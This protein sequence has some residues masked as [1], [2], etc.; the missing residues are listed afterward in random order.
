MANTAACNF[1]ALTTT[2][3]FATTHLGLFLAHPPPEQHKAGQVKI[4][5]LLINNGTSKKGRISWRVPLPLVPKPFLLNLVSQYSVR[6]AF[7]LQ[8]ANPE[9]DC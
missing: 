2:L 7:P 1:N 5:L 6:A 9:L 3:H 8:L 4:N